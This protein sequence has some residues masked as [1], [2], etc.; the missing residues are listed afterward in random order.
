LPAL[1]AW[2]VAR[3]LPWKPAITYTLIYVLFAVFFFAA[4]YLSPSLDFPGAVAGKQQQFLELT[5][6]SEIAVRTLQPTWQSFFQNAPQAF[7]L[8]LLRP[9][10][11]DIR[12]LLSL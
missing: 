6:S 5:G 11:S 7:S 10:F 3:R 9:Y 8:S 12:H 1:F 2:A 4:P